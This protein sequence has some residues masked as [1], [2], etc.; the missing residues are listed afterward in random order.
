MPCEA[1]H[2]HPAHLPPAQHGLARPICS[3]PTE[4]GFGLAGGGYG[5]YNFCP[6]CNL[7]VAKSQDNSEPET[8]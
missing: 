8:V 4:D 2:E 7:V 3:A 1:P 5:P 6:V